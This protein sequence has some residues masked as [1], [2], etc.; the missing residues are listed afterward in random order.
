MMTCSCFYKNE[1]P[2]FDIKKDFEE[3]VGEFEP[4]LASSPSLDFTP[5]GSLVFDSKTLE[6]IYSTPEHQSELKAAE[7]DLKTQFKDVYKDIKLFFKGND[8]YYCYYFMSEP[9]DKQIAEIKQKLDGE[10]QYLAESL[11]P[12]YD[13]FEKKDGVKVNSIIV[14][15]Y[16]NSGKL[17][18]QIVVDR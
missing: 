11:K 13:D 12:V 1:E 16:T 8:M 14:E 6:E 5:T 17:V 9:D 3:K 4:Q 7:N 2:T 18:T 15:Y 10:R